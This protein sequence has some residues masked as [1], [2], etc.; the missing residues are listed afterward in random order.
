MQ[1]VPDEDLLLYLQQTSQLYLWEPIQGG[2][3][4]LRLQNMYNCNQQTMSAFFEENIKPLSED[5]LRYLIVDLRA[6]DG[7]DF[8]LFVE[9]AKWL[10]DKVVE[11]RHLYIVVGT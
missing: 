11:D 5:S 7:G 9:L 2:G 8:T 10:P 1:D 3:G 6:N 4:Y